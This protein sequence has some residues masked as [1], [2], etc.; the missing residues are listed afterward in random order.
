VWS[1]QSMGG[2]GQGAA[3]TCAAEMRCQF[4]SWIGNKRETR[5]LSTI[6][7]IRVLNKN[8]TIINGADP[9]WSRPTLRAKYG[10]REARID[11]MP[12]SI[13]PNM[14]VILQK[15]CWHSFITTILPYLL[16]SRYTSANPST[17]VS[18]R[19][20]MNDC[21]LPLLCRRFGSNSL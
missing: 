6:V 11:S 3:Q 14:T 12:I 19:K 18:R 5:R 21:S 9:A 1:V 20:S 15:E 8:L 10:S 16:P 4:A 17:P 7:A 2:G 13:R